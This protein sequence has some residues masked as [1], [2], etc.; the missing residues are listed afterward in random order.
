[1]AKAQRPIGT[2]VFLQAMAD[3]IL[4]PI[5]MAGIASFGCRKSLSN[6]ALAAILGAF[7][8]ECRITE[9]IGAQI[10]S[11][12]PSRAESLQFRKGRTNGMGN[13]PEAGCGKPLPAAPDPGT[14][15]GR[16]RQARLV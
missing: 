8:T 7:A 6:H 15:G 5:L 2:T 9:V 4:G 11:G 12:S 3:A 1:M 13:R 16:H 10:E 14:G